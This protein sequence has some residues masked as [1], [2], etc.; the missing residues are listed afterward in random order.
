MTD[1]Q[2]LR[3]KCLPICFLCDII[4]DILNNREYKIKQNVE[5]SMRNLIG[6][7]TNNIDKQQE[8]ESIIEKQTGQTVV[9]SGLYIK[10]N[11]DVQSSDQNVRI[12]ADTDGLIKIIRQQAIDSIIIDIDS[13]QSEACLVQS[14]IDQLNLMG[15]TVY[16]S[17][18]TE[19][20]EILDKIKKLK[21]IQ[22]K[23]KRHI[24]FGEYYEI[25]QY[26]LSKFDEDVK[27]I[28]DIVGQLIGVV[29]SLP[30]MLTLII[31]LKLESPGSFI[32][33]QKRVGRNGRIFYIHKVRSMYI[34]AEKRKQEL[35]SKN[36]MSGHMFKIEKDPRITKI[37]HFIRKTSIDELPQFFDV[38]AGSMSLIGTRPPTID[39]F[40][41][42]ENHHKRRLSMKPGITGLWQISGRNKIQDFE[43][44]VQLDTSYIDNWSIWY[45]IK[46]LFK[47]IYVVF[48]GHG[49]E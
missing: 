49:A 4:L 11:W 42:Y 17:K 36:E 8:L 14:L 2:A 25:K 23:D 44:I 1:R 29:I 16:L 35:I 10:N 41:Q 15:I 46:I 31:P 28:V 21:Y 19:S 24:K 13:Q 7:L 33:K 39:E 20:S 37:G 45:D 26:K 32:F 48:K 6:I 40:E 3:D 27:R 38:L 22:I 5:I 47:T 30:I 43:E 18:S 34:D 12:S 9:L